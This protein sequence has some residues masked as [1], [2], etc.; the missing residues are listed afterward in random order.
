VLNAL[1]HKDYS[2][3]AP[4]QIRVYRDKLRISN[5]GELPP[6]WT[7]ET[8]LKTH[9]SRPPNP[10]IANA[11]FRAGL[12][13]A[14][15]RGYEKIRE[16]CREAGAPEPTVAM[17]GGLRVEWQWQVPDDAQYPVARPGTGEVTTEVTTEV[18]RLV[19]ALSG[20][21]TRREL[22]TALKL[23]NDE[24]FRKA[25]LLPALAAGVIEMTIPDKPNSRLQKYRLLFGANS[26]S[27]KDA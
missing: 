9:D 2:S 24:H 7:A 18:D 22:Q 21:M 10:D 23:K 4:I 27:K 5:A 12:I 26:A 14:W 11:F 1:I 16:A 20:E 15:G 8:L 25:Y 19:A 6:S 3:G 17:E 13:E